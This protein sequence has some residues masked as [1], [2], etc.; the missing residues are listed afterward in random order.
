MSRFILLLISIALVNEIVLCQGQ[1]R[2]NFY[3]KTCPKAE[4]IVKSIIW[5][6]VA[7]NATLPAKFLRMHFHDCFVRGCDASVL[8]DSTRNNMAE[9]TAIPNLSLG[10]FEEIDEVKTKLEKECPGV[11]SCA[12]ILALAARDS[13]SFQFQKPIWEVVTGRRD[14]LISSQSEALN[15]IPSPFFNFTQLKQSFA[16]KGLTV[17]DLVVLSGG[18]TIGVGHCNFFSN[19]LYNFTGKGDQDPSLNPTYAAALK[20]QCRSLADNT[21]IVPMDPPSP[22]SFDNSYY[23][24]LKQNKGLFTSDAALLTNKGSSN[25]VDELIDSGKFFTEFAQSMKRMGAVQVLTGTA[26][27]IRKNCR[28]EALLVKIALY[29]IVVVVHQNKMS[30]LIL[31]LI[32]VVL[33]NEVV[34]CQGQLRKNFYKKTCPK[35]EGIVK[36]I[37]WKHVAANATLP[38]NF[39][40]MHF[41]DCFVRGCDASVLLDSTKNNL[42]EKAAIPNQSLGGFEEIDEV[43]TKLEKECPGVVSCADILALATRDSVSFQFQKDVWEVVTGRRDGLISIQSEA[44]NNIPSPF[45]NFTQLKQSFADKGLTVRDL[46]VL[47]GGHTIGVGHC[48]VFSNRLYNFTGKGDQDPSLNPTYAASLKT[49]C[50]SLADNTTIVPMDPDSPLT[51][52]NSYYN[53][54]KQNKGLFTSDAA[55]LTNKGSSKI[56]AELLDS[57]KFFTEFARSMKRMGA[58]QVLTGTAGEIRRNCRLIN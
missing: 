17:H 37:I 32:S 8:L 29:K 18:H 21:T 9:K 39:L 20:T 7:A 46:V 40:R 33:V 43:K 11:V 52:D 53:I 4:G 51:F 25:I 5:K 13:V 57:G 55:L 28:L 30:R 34:L 50:R 49:Q 35:A 6:H 45:F 22:L 15:N 3:E 19:R 54:L 47:S 26:G 58:V 44:L 42:A 31:L 36:S 23:N 56:F 10:G 24:I 38:A 12:D 1:L 27:E 2:K 48:N 16:N 14:G 41:H